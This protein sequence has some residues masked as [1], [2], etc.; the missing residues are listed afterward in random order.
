MTFCAGVINI[1]VAALHIRFQYTH[2]VRGLNKMDDL[3]KGILSDFEALAEL[4]SDN[5]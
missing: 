5:G 4:G 1:D 3:I 2:T